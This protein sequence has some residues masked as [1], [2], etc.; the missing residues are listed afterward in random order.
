MAEVLRLEEW[1]EQLGN[2]IVCVWGGSTDSS[3][4]PTEFML[5]AYITRILIVGRTSAASMSLSA[6]QGWTQVWRSPGAKEWAC[7]LGILGHM[8]GPI[9]IVI[10]PEIALTSKIISG[11]RIANGL[12]IVQRQN[13]SLGWPVGE[14]PDACFFPSVRTSDGI[15]ALEEWR[16]RCSPRNLDFKSV[17]PQLS[18]GGYA[19]MVV[20]G[21]WHWY[22]PAD[23]APLVSLT[24]NQI[25]RQIQTLGIILEK[26]LI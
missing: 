19:L 1:T 7:L 18:A 13:N 23:S 8:P 15:P 16:E 9:L 6:D 20:K 11:L 24:V 4:L 14:V 26:T 12:T 17:L 10:S 25:A 3:W 21:V 5:T 22:K 2:K